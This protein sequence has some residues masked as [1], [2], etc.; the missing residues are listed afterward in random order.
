MKLRAPDLVDR[1]EAVL[2]ETVFNIRDPRL[3]DWT[4]RE[5]GVRVGR[6]LH[7]TFVVIT[8]Y[9]PMRTTELSARLGLETSTVSRYV[10]ALVSEG[11][12]E[13]IHDPADGRVR[14]VRAT[15]HGIKVLGK[16][17]VRYRELLDDALA[18]FEPDER[19][20]LVTLLGR[21]SNGLAACMEVRG[22]AVPQRRR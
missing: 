12:V 7:P 15:A 18:G 16:L 4:E 17:W 13:R 10:N 3:H 20:A 2:D 9:G 1:L 6:N 19:D 5:S 8:E 14:V 21:F 22:I 11:L